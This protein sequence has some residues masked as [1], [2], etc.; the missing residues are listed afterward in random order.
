MFEPVLR[1]AAIDYSVFDFPKPS[2]GDV[3]RAAIEF[4]MPT[5]GYRNPQGDLSVRVWLVVDAGRL[6][7][8]APD[9]YP[10]GVVRRTTDPPADADGRQRIVRLE[11]A[12]NHTKLDLMMNSSEETWAVLRMESIHTPFTRGDIL[13]LAEMFVRGLDIL[14]AMLDIQGLRQPEQ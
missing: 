7:V 13:A 8:I 10:A 6:S 9:M 14:D 11:D 3:T 1:D 5:E 12:E 4:S 2:E